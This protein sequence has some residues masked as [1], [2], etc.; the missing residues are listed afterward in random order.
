MWQLSLAR[1]H[2]CPSGQSVPVN[3]LHGLPQVDGLWLPLNLR[4][5]IKIKAKS[6]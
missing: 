3:V 2:L 6:Q 5:R 4:R 1:R